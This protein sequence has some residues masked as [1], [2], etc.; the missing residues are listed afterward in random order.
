MTPGTEGKMP[1]VPATQ[2]ETIGVRE[3][4]G[5]A[6]SGAQDEDRELSWLQFIVADPR[7]LSRASIGDL[8]RAVVAKELFD[9]ALDEPR[10]APSSTA[11]G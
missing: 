4:I 10:V 7:R 6:I 2:I 8:N 11:F 3:H 5:I 1:V 9:R